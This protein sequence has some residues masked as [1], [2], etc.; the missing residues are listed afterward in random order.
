[1]IPRNRVLMNLVQARKLLG[2]LV[3]V[4]E[5]HFNSSKIYILTVIHDRPRRFTQMRDVMAFF[6]RRSSRL[7][8]TVQLQKELTATHSSLQGLHITVGG[9][10]PLEHLTVK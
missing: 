4:Q 7:R 9:E 1:M 2:F 10:A 6:P 8:E 5:Y 3:R